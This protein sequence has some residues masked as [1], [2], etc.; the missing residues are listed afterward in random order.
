M[1]VRPEI[2]PPQDDAALLDGV[3]AR[4]ARALDRL[5]GLYAGLV[6]GLALRIVQD[7]SEAEEVTQ[8]VFLY[9]W[10]QVERFDAG[11]G[12][13]MSWL[14]TLTRSRG[15][16]RLRSRSSRERRLEGLALEVAAEAGVVTVA[17]GLEAAQLAERREKVRRGL[18]ALPR[19][20]RQALEIAYF[21]GLSHSE[22]AARLGSPIGTVKTRIRQG[23]IRMREAL[24]EP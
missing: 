18:A 11:R 14:V 5:Y 21:E 23:M 19:E 12:N 24:A 2:S 3:R 1:G 4:D 7:A 17:D 8:D 15:I 16:D 9:L 13:L 10:Q 22:I 6:H 20:Q